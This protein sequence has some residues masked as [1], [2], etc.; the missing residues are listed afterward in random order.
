MIAPAE[1]AARHTDLTAESFAQLQRLMGSWGT[2]S[3]LS[4]SDLLLLVPLHGST[5]GQLVVLGQIR[6]TTGATLIR[7]DLVGHVVESVEWPGAERA[8]ANRE[9]TQG[10]VGGVPALAGEAPLSDE[11]GQLEFLPVP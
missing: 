2:L 11:G 7:V 6:P 9:I 8:V 10:V 1:I 3:D 4:F 5:D